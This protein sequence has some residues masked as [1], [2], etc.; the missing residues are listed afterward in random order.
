MRREKPFVT[1]VMPVFNE[2]SFIS[3]TLHQLVSQDYPPER[4][5]ILVID[6]MSNDRT[7][8]LVQQKAITH[9][10]IKL[11]DNPKRRSSSGRNIGFKNG[12]GEYFV[13]IDG[14]C[15]IPDTHLIE[16]IVT[17]FEE[18]G[19]DCLGRPQTLDPPGLSDFQKAVAIARASRLGHGSDSHIYSRFS[20]FISPV[21]N[22]AAYRKEVFEKVGYVD[23]SFDAC[24]DVEFN[25]RVEKA[26][27]ACY[28]DPSLLVKYYPRD[29]F[30]GLFKQLMRYGQGRRRFIYKH[31][32]AITVNQLIPFFFVL[33]LGIL[34]A[35][36]MTAT[37]QERISISTIIVSI[38][39]IFYFCGISL[40]ALWRGKSN[41]YVV[42]VLP[43]I[44][45][46]IHVSLGL[47]FLKESLPLLYRSSPSAS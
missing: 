4:M 16:N 17:C 5:E 37:V 7:R 18:S 43:L 29:S 44:V 27:L 14:H 31:K 35:L 28:T 30:S 22:G 45:Y 36:L 15:Y 46:T 10:Q 25:F 40:W 23:E 19:A 39:Y 1:I 11:L 24:E 21:S 26:G 6:G 8:E 41:L 2:E 20:G 33:G 42:C 34:L 32:E 9:P 3:D 38:P 13:V 47:G 12:K